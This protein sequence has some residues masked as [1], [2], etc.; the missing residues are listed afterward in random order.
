MTKPYYAHEAF[1]WIGIDKA[2]TAWTVR[3][4]FDHRLSTM[5]QYWGKVLSG[6]DN[7]I[8]DAAI[9]LEN[10]SPENNA[11]SKSDVRRF[12]K[13]LLND[14]RIDDVLI[15]QWLPRDAELI[16]FRNGCQR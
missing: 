7:Q 8:I 15:R 9:A 10:L 6:D 1:P 12:Y 13:V 16:M 14:G 4:F 11:M 2:W 5:R 3:G